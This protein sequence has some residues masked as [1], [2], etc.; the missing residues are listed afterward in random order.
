M[1]IRTWGA[2]DIGRLRES[3]ED[4]FLLAPDLGLA[5]VADGMGGRLRGDVAS[6]LACNV[7]K[8]TLTANRAV[9]DLYRR[10]P[11]EVGRTAVLATLENAL[12]RAC[13]EVHRAAR[14]IGGDGG[15]MGTTMEALVV[16]G[17]TAF[18]AHVGD[19]RVYLI[20]GHEAHQLTQDHSLIQQRLRDGLITT[21]QARRSRNKNVIT[22]ALGVFPSVMV[23]TLTFDLDVGDRLLLCS[24]GLYKYVGL[25]ELEFNLSGAVGPETVSRLIDLAVQ[26]GG[27]DNITAVLCAV[28]AGDHDSLAADTTR[29]SAR[30]EVLR[31]VDLFQYCTYRE[32]MAI[33]QGTDQRTMAANQAIF[34]EGEVGR[35]CFVIVSGAVAIEKAGRRL[36]VLGPGEYFGEMSFIDSP[37]RSAAART[38]EATEFVVIRRDQFLQLVKQDSDLAVKLMWQLLRKFTRLVRTTNEQLVTGSLPV[39][40]EPLAQHPIEESLE[41]DPTA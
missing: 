16:V 26:R 36:A 17:S 23:D 8:E 31:R 2:T 29:A 24:D 38:L 35:E 10:S 34:N 15:S 30:M 20:R 39:E 11:G 40:V 6:Q 19:S 21:E 27:R 32:L 28:D 3:N 4:S 37:R 25:R 22:R 18:L 41:D 1:K 14:D 7:L 9:F 12:Q 5:A 13:E 33:C